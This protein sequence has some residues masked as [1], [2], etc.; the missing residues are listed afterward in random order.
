MGVKVRQKGGKWYVFIDH[1]G[2]RKAKAVG[3]KE[4][5]EKVKRILDAK[6][7]LG[8][9]GFAA[10]DNSETFKQYADRWMREH[11]DLH[12]KPSTAAGYRQLL[13]LYI[14]PALGAKPLHAI[15][16]S[17][18]KTFLTA[19]AQ[20][21]KSRRKG[22][23][24]IH[25][26]EDSAAPRVT[27]SRNTLRLALSTL[28]VI[29]N[30]AVEDG[31]VDKNPAAKLGKMTKTDRPKHE[32]AAMSKDESDRLLA[33]VQQ[34]SPDYYGLF[35][36]ALR[37]GLRR[38]E[39]V[40]LQWGDIQFGSDEQDTNRYI[41]VQRNYVHGNFTTPKSKKSRRVDLS[42]QLRRVLLDLREERLLKAY[43]AGKQ[44]ISEDFVFP[45]K[46]G[47]VLDPDNLVHYYFEPAL[48]TA[49][50]RKFR[51]HD[52][53]H[54]FG[55]Q[56]IQNGASLAYVRDQMGHSSIQV[57]ADVY[58]HLV[59]GANVRFVDSLD[60]EPSP[61]P[62]ATQAQPRAIAKKDSSR[63]PLQDAEFEGDFGERGRNRTFNL[64]IKSQLLCQLSYAPFGNCGCARGSMSRCVSGA[65]TVARGS[66]LSRVFGGPSNFILKNSRRF[67]QAAHSP[68]CASL[69][70]P[71]TTLRQGAAQ[72]DGELFRLS[73]MTILRTT[74]S[75]RLSSV[76]YGARRKLHQFPSPSF[77]RYCLG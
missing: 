2:K 3:S 58:G 69:L 38:G 1:N 66:H 21:P 13:R 71:H 18:V 44:S 43:E 52:L 17:D 33:A 34:L 20:K 28:R 50:L 23:E 46:A 7:A 10:A 12:C 76:R 57:T 56:L 70:T 27:L 6:L 61:R 47:T 45:S 35:L 15:T 59:P 53:R 49:G 42:A 67:W 55:S 77:T 39:L 75:I 63:E 72:E 37:G 32:A 8:E 30:H 41:L 31:L 11:A 22:G 54:T 14:E 24:E 74:P 62:D 64:L 4:S 73:I 9:F 19:L 68:R 26:N 40:A 16:R 51:F 48:T 25:E 36:I 60:G 65:L 29:F 5:A